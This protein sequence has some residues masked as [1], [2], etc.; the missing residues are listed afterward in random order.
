MTQG[1][2][3]LFIGWLNN[4]PRDTVNKYIKCFNA[5]HIESASWFIDGAFTWNNTD[6][7]GVDWSRVNDEWQ[8]VLDDYRRTR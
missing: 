5:S 7:M 2:F 3:D 8:G 6:A 1:E 4:Q